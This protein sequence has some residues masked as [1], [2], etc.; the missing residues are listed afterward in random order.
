[1]LNLGVGACAFLC[2]RQ[3]QAAIFRWKQ[4]PAKITFLG[5]SSWRRRGSRCNLYTMPILQSMLIRAT[6][7]LSSPVPQHIS[8]GSICQTKVADV[9]KLWFASSTGLLRTVSAVDRQKQE[10][11]SSCKHAL[12]QRISC[13]KSSMTFNAHL[14][15]AP[16]VLKMLI[17]DSGVQQVWQIL[18]YRIR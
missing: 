11:V 13:V 1:M 4:V 7:S 8:Q 10:P 2:R 18:I 6:I 12:K 5:Q 15:S 3:G 16:K 14:I 17:I 9:T